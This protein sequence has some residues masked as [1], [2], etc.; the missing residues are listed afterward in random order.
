[1][2]LKPSEPV[3][4]SLLEPTGCT[5]VFVLVWLLGWTAGTAALDVQAVLE[6]SDSFMAL[7][8]TP[9][10]LIMIVGWGFFVRNEMGGRPRYFDRVWRVR[11]RDY[12]IRLSTVSIGPWL[13]AGIT[14]LAMSFGLMFVL[15]SMDGTE[16]SLTTV[17]AAWG[18]IL[19]GSALVFAWRLW[20]CL[21][22]R[23]DLVLNEFTGRL[24]LPATMGR[25]VPE[26]VPAGAVEDVCLAERWVSDGEGGKNR[27]Y[28]LELIYRDV[29][30]E[31]CT[32][33]LAER[34]SRAPLAQLRTWL[35]ERLPKGAAS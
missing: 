11:R 1:M 25:D 12:E 7:F 14:A 17:A 15:A 4:C 24:T 2:S 20:V 16:P 30:G 21:S 28:R 10:H 35:L 18:S 31:R 13:A 32:E 34:F 9:F 5:R 22:G 33:P 23:K 29:S 8:L 3:A 26:V 19:A 6:D 27:L